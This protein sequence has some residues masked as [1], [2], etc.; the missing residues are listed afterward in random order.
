M[1]LTIKYTKMNI[2]RKRLIIILISVTALLMSVT[3]LLFL[4]TTKEYPYTCWVDWYLGGQ[5]V[6]DLCGGMGLVD[7]YCKDTKPL[8]IY[9]ST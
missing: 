2:S 7:K 4:L 8:Q 5:T 1:V 3:F 9:I 6:D